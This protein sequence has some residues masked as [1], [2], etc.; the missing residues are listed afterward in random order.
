MDFLEQRIFDNP[1]I[2]VNMKCVDLPTKNGH[3]PPPIQSRK[4]Y[5]SVNP[6]HVW[7]FPL[8]SL[9]LPPTVKHSGLPVRA[10]VYHPMGLARTLS[11]P[12]YGPTHRFARVAVVSRDT[13]SPQD[14][15]FRSPWGPRV[16]AFPVPAGV[17]P[18]KQLCF[19]TAPCPNTRTSS[20][21]L[22]CV[23]AGGDPFWSPGLLFQAQTL[24]W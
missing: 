1:Q 10:M 24:T 8:H 23:L 5:Q 6:K 15:P 9:K 7:H 12:L 22:D 18:V 17:A 21:G 3:A 13:D 2:F 19:Q 14:R 11:R 20:H 4:S 16:W